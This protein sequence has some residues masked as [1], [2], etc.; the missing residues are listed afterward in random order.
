MTRPRQKQEGKLRR[1]A[2]VESV[3]GS[4]VQTWRVDAS[5]G[6]DA[7]KKARSIGCNQE[8]VARDMGPIIEAAQKAA[9]KEGM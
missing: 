6:L 9:G 3:Q 4:R 1:F 7:I 2:I 5:D 8:P